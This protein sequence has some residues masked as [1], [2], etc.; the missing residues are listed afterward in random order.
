MKHPASLR[1]VHDGRS[2]CSR[3]AKCAAVVARELDWLEMDREPFLAHGAVSWAVSEEE[4]PRVVRPRTA[5]QRRS[6]QD[7]A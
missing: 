5:D 7:K 6:R 3:W 1:S 4:A 2:E